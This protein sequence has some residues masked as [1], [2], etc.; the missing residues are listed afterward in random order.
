MAKR[1]YA[2]IVRIVLALVVIAHLTKGPGAS[3][4]DW[5]FNDGIFAVAGAYVAVALALRYIE[6]KVFPDDKD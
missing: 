3:R 4:I 6:A 1:V 5:Y 2:W